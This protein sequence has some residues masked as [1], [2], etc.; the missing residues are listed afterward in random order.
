[1]GSEI[2]VA[3]LLLLKNSMSSERCNQYW[4]FNM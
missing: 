2:V 3:Y 4:L 1:M